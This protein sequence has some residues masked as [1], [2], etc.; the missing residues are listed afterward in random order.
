MSVTFEGKTFPLCCSGCLGE[1]NDNPEKY[2]KK[3]ALML[4]STGAGKPR[5]AATPKARGRDDAFA[6]DVVSP[7]ESSRPTKTMKKNP[8][9]STAKKAQA[10]SDDAETAAK[11]KDEPTPKKDSA[12]T[13]PAKPAARAATLLR[14]GRT[15]ERA[16]KTEQALSNYRQI[17]KNFPDTPS[18]KTAAERIKELEKDSG[19]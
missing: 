2:V 18:A 19:Q 9:A 13:P 17:V 10:E 11:S 6:R 7:T 1:F 14:L 3:A 8:A 16:G 15:L 12:K 4:S 5:S